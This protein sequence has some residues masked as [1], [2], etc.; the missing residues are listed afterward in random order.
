MAIFIKIVSDGTVIKPSDST[1]VVYANTLLTEI[2]AVLL[3]KNLF[4]WFL[5]WFIN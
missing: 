2:E 4:Y 1:K 5:I 3:N